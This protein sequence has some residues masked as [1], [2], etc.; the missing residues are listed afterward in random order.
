MPNRAIAQSLR[1]K[2]ISHGPGSII[3]PNVT[4]GINLSFA[5]L[6][7]NGHMGPR[8]FVQQIIPRIAFRNPA[9]AINVV[10]VKSEDK[11]NTGV[12]ATMNI[13]GEN[14]TSIDIKGLH[15]DDILSKLIEATGAQTIEDK[16]EDS[17]V[18][19]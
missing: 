11:K 17:S 10:R 15:S 5:Q 4:T 16:A 2:N 1:L 19:A 9:L 3:I 6:N 14:T 12:Q 13:T 8:K 7:A 18:I